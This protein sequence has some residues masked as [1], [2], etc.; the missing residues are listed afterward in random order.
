[1]NCP[2]CTTPNDNKEHYCKS[3]NLLL[4]G[5]P[6]V[7]D[8]SLG[9][10]P[11][12]MD[13]L[14]ELKARKSEVPCIMPRVAAWY[15]GRENGI[16]I[17]VDKMIPVNVSDNHFLRNKTWQ[18][19]ITF[20]EERR[21]DSLFLDMWETDTTFNPPTLAD[22]NDEAYRNRICFPPKDKAKLIDCLLARINQFYNISG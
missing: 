20:G 21:S 5:R 22:F 7:S 15:N 11:V 13:I 9:I 14:R 18:L 3:C 19:N 10:K 1:M 2:R 16:V 4:S 17:T 8:L 6:L 12:A